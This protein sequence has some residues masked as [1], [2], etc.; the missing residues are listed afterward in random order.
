MLLKFKSFLFSPPI[1]QFGNHHIAKFGYTSDRKA[2]KKGGWILVTCWKLF[3][4][5]HNFRI[6]FIKVWQHWEF[7][8]SKNPFVGIA[9]W[10][11]IIIIIIIF[12]SP[13]DKNSP[14]KQMLGR[15]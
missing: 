5:C 14:Q 1:S 9:S 3:S 2:K 4:K 15:R 13:S 12:W 7:F 6:F 8:F 10:H 11:F